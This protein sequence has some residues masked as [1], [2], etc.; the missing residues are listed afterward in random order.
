[1][2]ERNEIVKKFNADP[3]ARVLLFSN[4]GAVGLNLTVASVV[5]L[6]VRCPPMLLGEYH[7]T[8]T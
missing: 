6:F 3:S 8:R 2:D 1:M 7:L 5:I 4:V